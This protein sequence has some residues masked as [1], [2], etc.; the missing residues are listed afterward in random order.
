[1]NQNIV[2]CKK[3]IAIEILLN[4]FNFSF[5]EAV[6]IGDSYS[7]YEAALYNNVSFILRKTKLN[8]LLQ[9]DYN[10]SI[11]KDFKNG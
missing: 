11:I 8:K 10:L 9:E 7:D 3:T 6:M 2:A 1:M 4:E 5:D